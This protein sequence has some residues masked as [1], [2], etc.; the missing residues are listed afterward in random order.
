MEG[1]AVL[2]EGHY[3]DLISKALGFGG[4]KKIN[5]KELAITLAKI[6]GFECK[7]VFFYTCP[8]FQSSK[9]TKDESERKSK[10]D[11]FKSSLEKLGVTVREGRLQ[12]LKVLK[13]KAPV[14]EFREKGVDTLVTI[15]MLKSPQNLGVKT[16]IMLT[17]DTDF[18]PAIKTV[19]EDGIK[20]ILYYYATNEKKSRFSISYYLSGVCDEESLLTKEILE[21]AVFPTIKK[22]L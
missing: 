6:K 19:K 22:S 7:G 17:C 4:D 13:N 11:R 10:Y 9:P 2:I 15:D 16:I 12:K 3:L 14:S 18:V 1:A 21:K 20:V 8:P 5:V